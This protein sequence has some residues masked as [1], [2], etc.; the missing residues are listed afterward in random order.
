M[1]TSR[2]ISCEVRSQNGQGRLR[3]FTLIELLVVIAII[4]I[5]A[6]MLLPAL[7]KAKV[8]A[9]GISCL[10]NMKQLQIANSL[11]AGDNME[12]FPGNAGH[13]YNGLQQANG[14]V[15]GEEP[16]DPDWVAG[17]YWSQGNGNATPAGA[18]TNVYLLGVLGDFDPTT[19]NKIRGSIG[20]YVKAAG[21]YK[22]PADKSIDKVSQLPRVR[23]CSANGFIGPSIGEI[24]WKAPEVNTSY[25]N[26]QKTTDF[27]GATGSP[28]EIFVYVDENPDSLNDGFMLCRPDGS[29]YGDFPA[30]NHGNASSFSFA[31]GHSEIHRWRDAFLTPKPLTKSPTI[32][33]KDS[34][35]NR[36]LNTHTSVFIGS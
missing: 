7:S 26:Y 13:P 31:D 1:N 15:I 9:Q 20:A 11:Y 35:D 29:V 14:K 10:N 24:T 23:S 30:N 6:A 21:S 2:K 12:F 5:L 32:A 22:C 3:G 27:G 18:E 34:V 25:K 36:W 19:G 33:P 28:S 16:C 8:R 4:A 17:D